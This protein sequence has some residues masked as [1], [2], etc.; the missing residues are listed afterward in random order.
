[1]VPNGTLTELSTFACRAGGGSPY[2]QNARN[3]SPS[4]I[5][6]I[7]VSACDC[8]VPQNVAWGSSCQGTIPAGTTNTT[9]S[10]SGAISSTE[11]G[12]TG[13]AT[14]VC[15][16]SGSGLAWQLQAGSTC[17]QGCTNPV[18][19]IGQTTTS[20]TRLLACDS[21]S[22]YKIVT[23]TCTS[24]GWVTTSTTGGSDCLQNYNVDFLCGGCGC[25]GS[26]SGNDAALNTFRICQYRFPTVTDSQGNTHP[27]NSGAVGPYTA[28]PG[29]NDGGVYPSSCDHN[30]SSCNMLLT[31]VSCYYSY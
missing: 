27:W 25:D 16:D 15:T 31:G 29:S 1:M 23:Q 10:S 17:T 3:P 8:S 2:C 4:T 9:G 20:R 14:Y 6:G 12:T 7:T 30:C 22:I 5:P 26:T 19:S 24:S 11:P 21:G 18:G 28:E 13:S